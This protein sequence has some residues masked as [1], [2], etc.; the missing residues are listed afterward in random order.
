MK[1][2][3]SVGTHPQPFDR[4]LGEMDLLAGKE[5]TLEVFGQVG[6]CDYKPKNFPFERFL[7][8]DEF[9]GKISWADIVVSH[10]GAGTLINALRQGKRLVIVPRLQRFGEHTND[11]QLDLARAFEKE[12]KG[13]AVE[14]IKRLGNAIKMAAAFRPKV[15]SSRQGLVK[16]VKE[17]IE[18]L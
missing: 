14:E 5:K 12:G 18:N 7:N 16:A 13:I 1:V 9:Q 11:H 8:D 15:G 10:G 17:F 2:F 3:V 6:N 4:L